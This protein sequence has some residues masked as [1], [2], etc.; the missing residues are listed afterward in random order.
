MSARI[1]DR[2]RFAKCRALM[3][4]GATAGERDAGRA[5]A[6]RVA[7]AAGLS[8]VEALAVLD[9]QVAPRSEAPPPR[10][11]SARRYAWAQPKAPPE[12]ITV[13]EILRQKE[14]ALQRRKRAAARAATRR[15]AAYEEQERAIQAVRQAQAAQDR[16]WAERRAQQA[17]ESAPPGPQGRGGTP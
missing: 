11:P 5:A 15:R 10:P 3:E 4:R 1:L 6:T 17:G 7:A 9:A 14:A 8:L 12:P 13:E 16:D 2:D